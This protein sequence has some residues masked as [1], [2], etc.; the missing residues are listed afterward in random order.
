MRTSNAGTP[1]L[2]PKRNRLKLVTSH[3]PFRLL[4][5]KKQKTK[6]KTN[7]KQNG[8]S[9]VGLLWIIILILLKPLDALQNGS[10]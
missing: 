9:R 3:P 8:H 10:F 2:I 5:R 6:T 4:I 7:V 1:G